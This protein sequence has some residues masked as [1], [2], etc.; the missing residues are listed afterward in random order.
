M[1]V[2]SIAALLGL[3]ALGTA[4]RL[5]AEAN[6]DLERPCPE[7]AMANQERERDGRAPARDSSR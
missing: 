2:A 4:I 7:R 5:D 1:I 6:A 3:L